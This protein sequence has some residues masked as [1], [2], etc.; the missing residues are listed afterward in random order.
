MFRI[1]RPAIHRGADRVASRFL[2]LL[3]AVV[4]CLA[5]RLEW[6]VEEAIF[7]ATVRLDVIADDS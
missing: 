2:T 7:V 5:Q 4:V 6:S 3:E 1:D